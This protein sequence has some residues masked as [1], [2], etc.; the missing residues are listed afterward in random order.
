[1]MMMF[2]ALFFSLRCSVVALDIQLVRTFHIF[3]SLVSGLFRVLFC[4]GHFWR[5]LSP[6]QLTV[7]LLP[8]FY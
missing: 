8:L 6:L 5:F 3:P 7:A 4:Q 2:A 1:M